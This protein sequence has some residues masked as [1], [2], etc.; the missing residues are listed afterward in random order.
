[1]LLIATFSSLC[2]SRTENALLYTA[3]ENP[4]EEDPQDP[5]KKFRF[6]QSFGETFVGKKNPAL[7]CLRWTSPDDQ[8]S[9]EIDKLGGEVEEDTSTASELIRLKPTSS[10]LFP[11]TD[12]KLP[13]PSF[14]LG[15]AIFATSAGTSVIATAY[16]RAPGDRKLGIVYCQN[17][18]SMIVY[19]KLPELPSLP[20][21]SS[22]KSEP[23]DAASSADNSA[24]YASAKDT[25]EKGKDKLEAEIKCFPLYSSNPCR[26]PRIWYPPDDSSYFGKSLTPTLVWLS[27]AKEPHGACSKLHTMRLPK[28]GDLDTLLTAGES[29]ASSESGKLATGTPEIGVE[30][31]VDSVWE[32]SKPVDEGGFPGLYVNQLPSSP[33]LL[34]DQRLH[35]V[36]VSNWGCS[37]TLLAI[38]L[39]DGANTRTIHQLSLPESRSCTGVSCDGSSTLVAFGSFLSSPNEVFIGE[40]NGSQIQSGVRWTKASNIRERGKSC[41][42]S[43]SCLCEHNLKHVTYL[44]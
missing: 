17:R 40:V 39:S 42:T 19:F 10:L 33:F 21:K 14:H 36:C 41:F 44:W 12:E 35:L 3:E 24:H 6:T 23:K 25:Q 32:P 27:S 43:F 11:Q 18:P 1:M 30:T 29:V 8:L 2:F 26:S 37:Q 5:F 4:P 20:L 28:D 22:S 9:K 16:L 38:P 7:F 34:L 13:S 15:Q 31:V